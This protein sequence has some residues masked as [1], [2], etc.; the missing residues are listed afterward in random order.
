MKTQL[1]FLVTFFVVLSNVNGQDDKD[2]IVTG[3]TR[4][5]DL[6]PQFNVKMD[7]IFKQA[8]Y[9]VDKKLEVDPFAIDHLK[10][11]FTQPFG[12]KE[13]PVTVEYKDIRIIGLKNLHGAGSIS[14][15]KT[16]SQ[17]IVM[18]LSLVCEEVDMEANGFTSVLGI[19]DQIWAEGRLRDNVIPVR[20]YLHPETPISVQD[21]KHRNS[22]LELRTTEPIAVDVDSLRN[23]SHKSFDPLMSE[24]VIHVAKTILT[25]LSLKPLEEVLKKYIDL[26]E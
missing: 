8:L 15:F 19:G 10:V 26:E 12:K 23:A 24:T 25:N 18:N 22:G 2:P 13:V 14:L 16:K 21:I 17:N 1:F 7:E 3:P 4:G 6:D 20:L 9:D 5:T 11:T